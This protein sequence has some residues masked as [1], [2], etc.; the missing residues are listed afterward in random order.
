M[1]RDLFGKASTCKIQPDSINDS[2]LLSIAISEPMG[3][4]FCSSVA[5]PGF[6]MFQCISPQSK[7]N[8]SQPPLGLLL[9]FVG[10]L[11]SLN[12]RIVS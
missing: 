7:P 12:E 9:A 6:H 11:K 8:A 1:R 5:D 3:I 10:F 2:L 4:A